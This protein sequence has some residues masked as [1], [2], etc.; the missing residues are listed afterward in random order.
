MTINTTETANTLIGDINELWGLYGGF[1]RAHEN[2]HAAVIRR[3]SHLEQKIL[4]GHGSDELPEILDNVRV[5]RRMRQ[6]YEAFETRLESVFA[7]RLTTGEI[8]D[9]GQYV[10]NERFLGLVSSEIELASIGAT[11]RVLFIGSGP[12]PITAI[13]LT[14]LS[15][16]RVDCYESE[17]E[18]SAISN[19]LISS[20]GLDSRIEVVN[21]DDRQATYG[22]YSLVLVAVLARPK[23]RILGSIWKGAVPGTRVVCRTTAGLRR[24]FYKETPLSLLRHYGPL[25]VCRAGAGQTISSVLLQTR[26][27]ESA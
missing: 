16:C 22:N 3:I 1:L 24:L 17:K 26:G 9:C 10:L 11:D 21:A 2:S 7:K 27:W 6:T 5:L 18:Y 13:L 25:S 4:S 23:R 8:P 14:H 19:Q 15:G 20:I 12:F